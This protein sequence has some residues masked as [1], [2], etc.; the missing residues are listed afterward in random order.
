ME[1]QECCKCNNFSISA[2]RHPRL[3]VAS[4]VYYQSD[5]SRLLALRYM[6]QRR[7]RNE[8]PQRTCTRMLRAVT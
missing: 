7:M 5:G 1:K 6:R 4:G 2:E 8:L 3:L